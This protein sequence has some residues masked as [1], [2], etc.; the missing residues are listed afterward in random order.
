ML[1]AV[2]PLY[3]RLQIS[4]TTSCTY[5]KV[6]PTLKVLKFL[7]WVRAQQQDAIASD[8]TSAT[9]GELHY[10]SGYIAATSTF[11]LELLNISG[12]KTLQREA[13]C[14]FSVQERVA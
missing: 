10:R 8:P 1:P 9:L 11:F 7:E 2:S 12:I 6:D 13:T 4:H 5:L 3:K 14:N